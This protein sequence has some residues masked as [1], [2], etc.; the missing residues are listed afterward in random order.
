MRMKNSNGEVVVEWKGSDLHVYATK[1]NVHAAHQLAEIIQAGPPKA[2]Y[3]I[4]RTFEERPVSV[5]RS[6]PGTP[7]VR[8]KLT[9][10]DIEE[11]WEDE[12]APRG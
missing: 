12:E 7:Y 2:R 1:F 3:R 11:V 5:D 9:D 10:A 6:A 4:V 8:E